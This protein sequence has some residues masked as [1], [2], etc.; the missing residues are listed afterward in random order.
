[1][2]Y[3]NEGQKQV[4]SETAETR[5]YNK[6]DQI[7]GSKKKTEW[8]A[9]CEQLQQHDSSN[10]A[11]SHNEDEQCVVLKDGVEGESLREL[12]QL[13]HAHANAHAHPCKTALDWMS[14]GRA[15]ARRH[16]PGH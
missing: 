9:R 1:M 4:E 2:S 6:A 12:R 8:Y 10:T 5:E 7:N 3:W 15:D 13:C 16:R 14:A 11:G